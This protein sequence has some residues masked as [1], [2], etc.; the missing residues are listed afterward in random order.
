MN[1]QLRRRLL[2]IQDRRSSQV[3][4]DI[5]SDL[6]WHS[7]KANATA[8]LG[9][10]L[11]VPA[12]NVVLVVAI[13]RLGGAASLGQY[14][15][16][17]TLF[18]L[19]ENLKSLGLTTHMVRDV[20]R[21]DV[22]ALAQ[23][24]SLVRIGIGG[25][26][27]TAPLIFVI[28]AHTNAS[29]RGLTVPALFMCLGLVPSAYVFANDALFLGLGRS[30][31]T[32][33][34]AAA[35]NLLR[36]IASILAI[37]LWHGGITALCAIYAA[38]RLFA[39]LVQEV[40]IRRHLRLVFPAYQARVT[41]A[42]L[43]SAPAFATVFVV[44]LI[45]FR[46]DVIF[47]GVMTSD[48]QVGI[49]TAA[50][51]L[52]TLCLI[53]PDGVMTAT[54]ALLSKLA[55]EKA[56]DDFKHLVE[57]T[58]Q[59]VAV[60]LLPVAVAGALFAPVILRILYG[61]KFDAA[62]PVMQILVWALLPFGVNR[63]LGD[64]LVARGEQKIVAR[65]V[66]TNVAVGSLL[67]IALI[68]ISGPTGAAWAFFYSVLG[69]SFVSAIISVYRKK[70]AGGL[71]IWTAL[72]ASVIGCIG[73]AVAGSTVARVVW[74]LVALSLA[75]AGIIRSYISA[76]GWVGVQRRFAGESNLAPRPSSS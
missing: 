12:L 2:P 3:G 4:A 26:L 61:P 44:P 48:Y 74:S 64:A 69:C 16:L 11:L 54:F 29:L 21:H 8:V 65:I 27:V 25:A 62:I 34:V 70:I 36:L 72:A 59:F 58:V 14:T 50:M 19:C 47:L 6:G 52:V 68:S 63:A 32:L 38:S 49:Y 18:V 1:R 76:P 41:S 24:R 31:L 39:A 22:E 40:L 5:R 46:M 43:R 9:A 30:A 7:L 33:F 23:Y 51:R 71:L 37:F 57:R 55:E 75:A 56:G 42:M 60:L 10:R 45:L 53:V 15:L 17:I 67:Y 13:A 73:F 66:L 20:A 28:A 35:E